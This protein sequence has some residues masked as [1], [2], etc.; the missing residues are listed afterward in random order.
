MSQ[1]PIIVGVGDFVNRST[2][3]ADA[4]EPLTLIVNAINLALQDT[5]LPEPRRKHLQ[6]SID[7]ID[8]VRTWTWPYDD[9]PNSIGQNL[10]VDAKHRFY[11]DHGGN[12]VAKLF[13]QAAR[14]IS[15]GETKV[16]IVTGGEALASLTACAAAKKLPPPGWTKTKQSVDSVF[17]PTGR[18]LGK[19]IGAMHSIGAPIQVYPLFENAFRAHRGQSIAE[20]HE[21]SAELYADFAKVAEK[22]PYAWN[23]G[24]VA[25]KEDIGTVTKRNRMICFPCTSIRTGAAS[26]EALLTRIANRSTTHER[27]QHDQ[28][29]RRLYSHLGLVR[30]RAKHP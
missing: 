8:V 27:L 13:D 3:L 11:S 7:S 14:R 18:D 12:K 6:A 16:A 9:L 30:R 5:E 1:I 15:K 21:E 24:K 23:Y 28:P 29:G 17:S 26:N 25:T 20:N 10:G 4:H 19:D 2:A 22:Q